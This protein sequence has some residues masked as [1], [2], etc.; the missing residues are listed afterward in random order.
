MNR[1]KLILSIT[2]GVIGVAV[3]ASA[4]FAWSAYSSKVT[5]LVGDEEEG[6]DGLDNVQDKVRQF[7]SKPIYPCLQSVKALES[8][9]TVVAEWKTDAYKLASRGD[10]VYKPVTPAQFKT[11]IVADAK[12]IAAMP[13]AVNGVFVKPGFAF[14]PFK[15]FVA[16]GK[17]PAEA[18]LPRLQRQWDDVITLVE[19][20]HNA[21]A[22]ELVE[23][24]YKVAKAEVQPEDQDVGKKKK[25][26][27]IQP[28]AAKKQVEAKKSAC[29]VQSYT[30]QFRAKPDALVKALNAFATDERFITVESMSFNRGPTDQLAAALGLSKKADEASSSGSRRRGRRGAVQLEE[31]KKEG[32]GKNGIVTDPLLDDPLVITL[33]LSVVDFGSLAEDTK[34][35]KEEK[36]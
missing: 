15:D 1:N 9:A 28:K 26:K 10:R 29:D 2:G 21:G 19:I 25:K 23:V 22:V 30:I 36:K 27:K 33:T 4:F 7:S 5:A 35:S 11:E 16:E 20:L 14:G 17:M 18:D 13:G 32:E 8:N 12:R 24:G 34:E 31:P 6:V 3:L